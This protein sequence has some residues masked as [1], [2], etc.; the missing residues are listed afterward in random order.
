MKTLV[1]QGG[2]DEDKKRFT[3]RGGFDDGSGKMEKTAAAKRRKIC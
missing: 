1:K 3:E 2:K